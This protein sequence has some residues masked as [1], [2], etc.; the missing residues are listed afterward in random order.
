LSASVRRRLTQAQRAASPEEALFA[1]RPMQSLD[2]RRAALALL[3]GLHQRRW[4]K[5]G[6]PGLFA[7]P[8]FRAFQEELLAAFH[9][10]G[11]LWCKVAEAQGTCVAGR[12]AFRL[13]GVYY[14]Y[15]SGFDDAAPAA[16]R[17]PG[18]A[19]LLD[20]IDDAFT[21]GCPTVDFL[22][23]D[24]PYKFELTKNARYN[25]NAVLA[26]RRPGAVH[27]LAARLRFAAW[28]AGR[29]RKLLGVQMRTRGAFRA[30]PGYLAFRMPRLA[31]KFARTTETEA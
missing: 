12:L 23:G 30:L 2:E 5:V 22:R 18:L 21:N 28:L 15:L 6:F 29:E 8:R 9:A 13:N 31:R 20:M 19:L 24:E 4:N 26:G 11:L 16:K 1:I 14:D 3:A 27:R 17:R 25:W 10:Q 7:D